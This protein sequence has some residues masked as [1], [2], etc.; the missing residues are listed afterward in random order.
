M[1]MVLK[2]HHFMIQTATHPN[3]S[4]SGAVDWLQP[5][6]DAEYGGHQA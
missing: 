2:R 1:K 6:T 5:V 3:V 4:Q